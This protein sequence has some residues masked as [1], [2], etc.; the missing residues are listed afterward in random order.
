M[1]R[2]FFIQT[3][4]ERGWYIIKGTAF[5]YHRARYALVYHHEQRSCIKTKKHRFVLMICSV[6]DT[7]D[8]HYRIVMICS[9]MRDQAEIDFIIFFV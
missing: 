2:N 1:A 9:L 6:F 8:M 4:A 7:D 3:E 5:V